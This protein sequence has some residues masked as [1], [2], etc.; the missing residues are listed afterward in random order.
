MLNGRWWVGTAAGVALGLGAVIA[1]E[2]A[3]GQADAAR[4]VTVSAQQLTINQRISQAAVKRSNDALKQLGTITPQIPLFAVSS[5]AVGSNLVRGRGATSAQRIDD[6]NYRVKFD[7]NIAACSWT[8]TA[9]ADAPPVS[10]AV[11]VRIAL[12]TTDAGRTQL[13]VRT[14]N[15]AGQPA[16][17]PF[18]IQVVC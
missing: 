7:R 11:T 8:G 6:G 1:V 4:P 16:N 10:D 5:G 18:H 15:A 13:V 12:D 9:S 14:S 17:S 3:T 2:G